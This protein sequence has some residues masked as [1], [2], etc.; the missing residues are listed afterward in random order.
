LKLALSTISIT[1]FAK[2]YFTGT[3]RKE[4]VDCNQPITKDGFDLAVPAPLVA[5]AL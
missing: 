5:P 3:R 2:Y 4:N 1:I